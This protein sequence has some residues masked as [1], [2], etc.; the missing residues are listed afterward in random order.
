[1]KKVQRIDY[2]FEF[3]R[4]LLGIIIAFGIC[5]VIIVMLTGKAG[6]R[7]AIYN[8]A[9]G[10]FTTKRRLG[11][12]LHKFACYMLTGAG[13]CFVYSSGRFSVISEGI[14]NLA[15]IF[16]LLLMF[17]TP[18]MTNLPLIVNLFIIVSV[19]VIAGGLISLI[20]AFGRE[21]LGA[22]ETV[23]STILNSFCYSFALYMLRQTVAD[24]SQLILASPVY[25]DNMR[26][27]RYW[28]NTNATAGIW[29]GVLGIIIAIIIFY[30][31]RIGAEI[32][33]CGSNMN[34]AK[35][36]GINTKRAMY[37]GQVL[38]GLF[39]GAA[40][41]VDCFGL[42]EYYRYSA[43]TVIGMDGLIVAVMARKKPLYVPLTAF[44]LAYIRCAAEV[45]NAN[46][47][48]PVEI[49]TML[50]AVIILFVAAEQFLAKTRQKAI[51]KAS[52]EAEAQGGAE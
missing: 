6:A 41:A 5:L 51:I 21:K 18:L 10:P 12:V 45:L 24:R 22:N 27:P 28:G 37:A 20:P 19:C 47:Q 2:F 31:T 36:S 43:L 52:Y 46:T 48:I 8:F 23:T 49:V 35:Y 32:R 14:I 16:A 7:D 9:I 29:V 13:M 44:V 34:F 4:V 15:P 1:M 39:A 50:Q 11:Q 25:P 26:F 3:L 42:Y 33:M 38:G 30:R 17:A 40:A